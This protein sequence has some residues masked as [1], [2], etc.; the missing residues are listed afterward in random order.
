MIR[1][2]TLGQY[3]PTNSVIHRL[4]PRTKLIGTIAFIVS[5]FL[6]KNWLGYAAATLFLAG[7]IRVSRVP[8]RYMMRGLKAIIV[9]LLITVVFNL[10]IIPGE[11]CIRD[12]YS[13]PWQRAGFVCL[14][15][16]S[17]LRPGFPVSGPGMDPGGSEKQRISG[18]GPAITTAV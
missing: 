2:I 10:F 14:P 7:V 9:L 17:S 13:I 18:S 5:L 4:D 11:M 16:D 3:Y 15:A 12:S 6:F 1:D 8:F